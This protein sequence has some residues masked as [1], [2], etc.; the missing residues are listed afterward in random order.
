M[1]RHFKIDL[2]LSESERLQIEHIAAKKTAT[3]DQLHHWIKRRGYRV[4]RSSV[5]RWLHHFR[6]GDAILHLRAQLHH[7]VAT[8]DANKLRAASRAIAG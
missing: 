4:A 7:R 3:I 5:G 6:Q 1:F 8:A 2:L